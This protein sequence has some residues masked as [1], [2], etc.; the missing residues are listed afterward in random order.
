MNP[1]VQENQLDCPSDHFDCDDEC[2]PY[3]WICDGVRSCDY[4]DDEL[5]CNREVS[6]FVLVFNV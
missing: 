2:Q 5:H 3:S 6:H 4:V 1:A